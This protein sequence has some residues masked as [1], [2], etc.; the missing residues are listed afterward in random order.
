M[1][2]SVRR[3]GF[4]ARFTVDKF[5]DVLVVESL[6]LGT[7]PYK[8]MILNMLADAMAEDGIRIRGIYE[9]SDA[10]VRQLE[11]LPRTK[12]FI[13]PEFDTNVPIVENGV[14]YLVDVKE[15]RVL[16]GS[17]EQPCGRRRN[18][19][20]ASDSVRTGLLHTH[21]LIRTELRPCRRRERPVRG[22]LRPCHPPGDGQR[23]A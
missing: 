21:R 20:S 19:P 6:A 9:R 4:S 23:P 13:G 14:R 1:P 8:V 16:S 12:G 15:D 2:G 22:C 10:K 11:G 17:E 7:E 18:R 3:G 5:G